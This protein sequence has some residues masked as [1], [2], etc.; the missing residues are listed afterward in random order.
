MV[1][2]TNV[3]EIPRRQSGD[4]VFARVSKVYRRGHVAA[5]R[6]V[7]FAIAAGEA[8][9]FIGPS[10]AGKTTMLRLLNRFLA[11][12]TGQV[13]IGGRDLTTLSGR[14][15]RALRRDTGMIYQ[16]HNL[17]TQL[18]VV[19]NVLAG[20]LGSWST[21][22]SLGSLVAPAAAQRQRETARKALAAV[23][24]E[25]QIDAMT[26]D[27]SGG[28]QQRVAIARVLVQDPTLILADE[29]V[30]SLDPRTAADVLETLLR[31]QRQGG[32]TLL[33]SIHNVDL[34]RRH[35]SRVIGLTDGRTVFDGRPD[36]LNDTV[37][38][39]IYGA[40]RAEAIEG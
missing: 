39:T 27:L 17:V 26:A 32:K 3:K 23:G 25:G 15:T 1:A 30:A 2:V 38:A 6:D 20:R 24:L 9:A 5:L 11:P 31:V 21:L 7:S 10:G 12:D 40:Q 4:V 18:R 8:V 16:Q 36:D 22:G 35:F 33:V 37:L 13:S 28:Q 29:P 19:H 34:V 14:D